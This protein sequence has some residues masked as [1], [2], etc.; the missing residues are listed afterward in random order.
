MKLLRL[1]VENYSKINRTSIEGG[2]S[3]RSVCIS[4]FHVND[5]FSSLGWRYAATRAFSPGVPVLSIIISR[6]QLE[7]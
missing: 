3:L 2:F 5:H 4:K 1:L 6:V 7:F